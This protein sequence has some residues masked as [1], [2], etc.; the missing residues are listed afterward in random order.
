[1]TV[2]S[3]NPMRVALIFAMQAEAMPLVC[4]LGLQD[5]AETDARLGFVRYAGDYRGLDLR[6]ATGGKDKAHGVDQI[7]T[8]AAVLNAYLTL[9][10]QASDLCINAGTAGGFVKRGAK[11][12][13]VIVSHGV[14]RYHDRRIPIPGFDAYGVG[15]Y[16]SLVLPGIASRLGLREGAISTSDSL[17]ATEQ[18]HARM[19]AHDTHAKE[20]EAAAIAWVCSKLAVPF[21]ALKAIT[22]LVDGGVATER[23]FLENLHVA[24]TRLCDRVH[25]FLDLLAE[26][27]NALIESSAQGDA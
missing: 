19:D 21:V 15:S 6:I 26:E 9:T 1:M 18:C 20:M 3:D 12:G 10:A 16:P 17:D 27:P 22:D 23:E 25:A 14:V 11:I 24:S 8:Q 4:A 2:H 13:D 7:G 5:R